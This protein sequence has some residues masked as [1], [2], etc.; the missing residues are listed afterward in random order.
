V[1]KAEA[2]KKI[3]AAGVVGAGG[4]GFPTAVKL[5]A[6]PEY[7]LVNGAECEPL[8]KVDQALMESRASGLLAAL[9]ALVEATG[10]REGLFAAKEHYHGAVAALGRE[11]TAFHN[12]RLRLVALGG[13]YPLGDEQVLVYE[14]LKR[15]VPEGGRAA[16]DRL[17][18]DGGLVSSVVIARPHPD[19]V[20]ALSA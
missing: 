7:I 4:A 9:A 20:R 15:I 14:A 8:L 10:A 12:L 18:Q 13:F 3:R 2:L 1:N 6:E 11:I 19:L 17:G 16:R 5:E